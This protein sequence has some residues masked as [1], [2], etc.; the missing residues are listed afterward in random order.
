MDGVFSFLGDFAKKAFFGATAL[1]LAFLNLQMLMAVF[2]GNVMFVIMGMIFFS[3]AT[4]VY[5]LTAFSAREDSKRSGMQVAIAWGGLGIS[6]AGELSMG[7]FEILR[8][9]NFVAIPPWLNTVTITVIQAA[10]I[11]H[12]LLGI[13]YFAASSEYNEALHRIFENSKR[14]AAEEK[15]RKER[16]N[17]EIEIQEKATTQGLRLT[18]SML[19][20][21]L[22][23]VAE[24]KAKLMAAE[25][26]R[27]FG[28]DADPA[29]MGAFEQTL[30]EY[31]DGYTT[32]AL[33]P[34]LV[35]DAEVK[36]NGR[37]QNK[38]NGSM[39]AAGSPITPPAV[40]QPDPTGRR[41][42]ENK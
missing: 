29:L 7:L 3:I 21:A 4:W 16:A 33:H 22:P 6:L 14:R 30:R 17:A 42:A 24:R 35:I 20:A 25:I 28:L 37:L 32:R 23:V 13:A 1:A 39:S 36:D 27:T 2:S 18:E 9:Q 10:I 40:I 12:L 15:I 31:R 5:L 19:E 41:K 38:S 11:I 26:A 34:E 8:M